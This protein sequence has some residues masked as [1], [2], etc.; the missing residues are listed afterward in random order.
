MRTRRQE[1]EK[2]ADGIKNGREAELKAQILAEMSAQGMKSANLEGV[3]RVVSKVTYHYEIRDIEALAVQMFKTM[4][5]SAKAGRPFSDGLL[6]QR[7]VSK[8]QLEAHM[9][10][11]ASCIEGSGPDADAAAA[12][13]FGV[14]YVAKN[15]LSITKA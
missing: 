11:V 6:L 5:E 3:G 8:E 9:E 2:E 10:A 15:D 4:L 14:K 13:M 12:T 1:L 7:R